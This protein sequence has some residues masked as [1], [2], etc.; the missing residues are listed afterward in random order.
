MVGI[1]WN[2]L[3]M[4]GWL[5]GIANSVNKSHSLAWKNLWK[6][7]S[8]IIY[9]K[10][11]RLCVAQPTYNLRWTKPVIWNLRLRECVEL[12][13][14]RGF[15]WVIWRMATDERHVNWVKYS[16]SKLQRVARLTE[17]ITRCNSKSGS[18]RHII[19]KENKCSCDLAGKWWA[20]SAWLHLT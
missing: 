7:I 6:Y 11:K 15:S 5:I 13:E 1:T 12:K 14:K 4:A 17:A 10:N 18:C 9:L 19:R 16:L 20:T 8:H 2:A 3:L